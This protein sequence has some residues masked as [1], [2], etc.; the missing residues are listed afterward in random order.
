MFWIMSMRATEQRPGQLTLTSYLVLGLLE[1]GGPST[2]YSL[3]SQVAAS[4]GHFWSFPHALLYKE[5]QRLVE[6]GLLTEQREETGRRRR[7]FAITESGRVA[8][9]QWLE[10]PSQESPQLRDPGLLQLFFMDYASNEQRRI[11]AETQLAIH[12]QSL[13]RYEEYIRAQRR[14]SISDPARAVAERWRGST[15]P[16]GPLYERAAIEFWEGVVA[17]KHGNDASGNDAAD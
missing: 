16:M 12:R 10:N 7:L 15:L 8:L 3:K 5:P 13:A 9:R 17:G 2:P 11:L 4:V 6:L 14:I 1:G